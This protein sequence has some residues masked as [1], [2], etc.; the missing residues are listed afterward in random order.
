MWCCVIEWVVPSFFFPWGCLILAGEGTVILRKATKHSPDDVVVTPQK[1][2]L[3]RF[4]MSFDFLKKKKKTSYLLYADIT[5]FWSWRD[6]WWCIDSVEFSKASNNR[7]GACEG[8]W[9]SS[10]PVCG[11]YIV[12]GCDDMC[13]K[14]MPTFQRNVLCLRLQGCHS[15]DVSCI[16]LWNF[17]ACLLD[18]MT[19]HPVR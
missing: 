16:F 1:R 14:N 6:S 19:S 3:S 10:I 13:G 17:D 12:P 15:E 7:H 11:D 9:G 2:G 4:S 5:V 8:F 18:C